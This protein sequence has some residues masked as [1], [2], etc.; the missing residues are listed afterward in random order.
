MMKQ[1]AATQTLPPDA[2]Q[3]MESALQEA[4]SEFG[5]I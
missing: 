3:M 5:I 1:I 2:L 4:Y